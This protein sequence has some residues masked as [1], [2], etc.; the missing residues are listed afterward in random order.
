[1]KY[2]VIHREQV[3]SKFVIESYK[4]KSVA[5]SRKNELKKH[6]HDVLIVEQSDINEMYLQT[7]TAK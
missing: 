1:M 4:D 2:W 7:R 6:Y 5:E 3:N